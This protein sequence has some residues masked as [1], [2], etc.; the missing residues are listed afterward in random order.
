M[1][2]AA[3]NQKVGECTRRTRPA[4]EPRSH[5][6]DHTASGA[7]QAPGADALISRVLYKERLPVERRWKMVSQETSSLLF[8]CGGH[9]KKKKKITF[10]VSES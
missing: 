2:E 10:D 3:F 1:N 4:D 5:V 7:P 6:R 9:Q 8:D